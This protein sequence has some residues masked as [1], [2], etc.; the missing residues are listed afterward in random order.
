MGIH[1]KCYRRYSCRL[2]LHLFDM[3][4]A[5]TLLLVLLEI[6]SVFGIRHFQHNEDSCLEE[7][8]LAIRR[9]CIEARKMAGRP[10]RCRN[11]SG[12]EL[13]TCNVKRMEIKSLMDASKTIDFEAV[14]QY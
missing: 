1:R 4:F 10:N 3:K 5:I 7:N 13:E 9:E 8:F 12:A 2:L 11:K 6:F 14:K